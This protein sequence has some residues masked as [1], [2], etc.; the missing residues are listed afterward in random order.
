LCNSLARELTKMPGS[1]PYRIIKKIALFVI[2]LAP[3]V[4]ICATAG[5]SP[6]DQPH[7]SALAAS[8][9]HAGSVDD[10]IN[11]ACRDCNNQ[12]AVTCAGKNAWDK[13]WCTLWERTKCVFTSCAHTFPEIS[14][15]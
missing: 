10:E 5:H 11:A 7:H 8:S 2:A 14:G 9:L 13:F 1:K 15:P 12:A 6:V 4:M 3:L